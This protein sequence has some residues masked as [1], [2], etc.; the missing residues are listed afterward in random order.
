[1]AIQY[2]VL[3]ARPDV[4]SAKTT[5]RR[6]TCRFARSTFRPAVAD[7]RQR[8]V[9]RGSE[10][11][12]LGHRPAGG[13][14]ASG[15]AATT[16]LGFSTVVRDADQRSTTPRRLFSMV[17]QSIAPAF[18]RRDSDDLQ[19]LL[20]LYLDQCKV[21][22]GEIYAFG[23]KFNRNLHMPMDAK[24]A[25]GWSPRRSRHPHEPG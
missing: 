10:H 3:R 5:H 8:A 15:V 2:G 14:S 13:P 4:T 11:R 18:R 6:R 7:C 23:A 20:S 12:I 24:S 19:D 9:G 22:R 1:M 17:G 21:A 16:A 25:T